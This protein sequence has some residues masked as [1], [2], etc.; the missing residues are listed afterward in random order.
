MPRTGQPGQATWE[1]DT[2]FRRPGRTV[3]SCRS[4]AT[5]R[6]RETGPG[7]R[8]P[9]SPRPRPA[10]GDERPRPGGGCR[11]G[12]V[13]RRMGAPPP[14]KKGPGARH[15]APPDY[16]RRAPQPPPDRSP[17]PP[18]PWRQGRHGEARKEQGQPQQGQPQSQE[19][20]YERQQPRNLGVARGAPPPGKAKDAR[21]PRPRRHRGGPPRGAGW[22]SAEVAG[23]LPKGHRSP[24]P[25]G[26]SPLP[27]RSSPSKRRPATVSPP[28]PKQA[29]RPK[30]APP[31][32]SLVSVTESPAP[33]T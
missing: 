18:S 22:V 24:S 15:R 6:E 19:E 17:A 23:R 11:F 29:P 10:A 21:T 31:P 25:H 27:L 8:P 13:R 1:P 3:L 7:Q 4:T 9:P 28:R 12:A 5:R 2:A 14:P 33:F 20:W 30:H 16:R 26:P 32:P